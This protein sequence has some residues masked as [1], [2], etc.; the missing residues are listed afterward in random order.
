MDKEKLMQYYN[1]WTAAWRS[2]RRWLSLTY[3]WG[4]AANAC[5]EDARRF[6]VTH[7]DIKGFAEAVMRNLV[8]EMDVL[9]RNHDG[10]DKVTPEEVKPYYE[11][12]SDAWK[13]FCSW[14]KNNSDDDTVDADAKDYCT[15]WAS[16][17]Y[18]RFAS[19]AIAELT[20]AYKENR[21]DKK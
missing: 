5:K 20:I 2:F 7:K 13:V 10:V 19:L 4:S 18:P 15:R 17:G 6:V 8:F 3:D 16:K 14:A 21:G 1:C 9:C 12:W 11:L